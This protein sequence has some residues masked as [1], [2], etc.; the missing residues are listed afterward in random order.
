[1][2]HPI[3]IEPAVLHRLVGGDHRELHHAIHAFDFLLRQ[4][5]AQR[6]EIALRCNLRSK[7]SGVEQGDLAGCGSTGRNGLPECL[8]V[9]ATRGYYADSSDSDSSRKHVQ[10]A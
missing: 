2:V 8:A 4:S 7:S 9:V 3:Q 1:M 5:R 6:I 10:L